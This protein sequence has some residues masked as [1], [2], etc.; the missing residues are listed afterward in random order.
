MYLEL[1]SGSKQQS[2]WDIKI[3]V[4]PSL[5]GF[6]GYGDRSYTGDFNNRKSVMGYYLFINRAIRSWYSKKQRTV[7]ILT[8]EAKY[9]ALGHAA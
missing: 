9:I 8:I 3:L 7:F 6:I 1:V 4:A 2:N 5:F